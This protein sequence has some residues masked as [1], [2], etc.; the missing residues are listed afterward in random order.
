MN[1][2]TSVVATLIFVACLP[3]LHAQKGAA[4]D[5]QS[6]VFCWVYLCLCV[7]ACMCTCVCVHVCVRVHRIIGGALYSQECGFR[8]VCTQRVNRV[9]RKGMR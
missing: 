6:K 8:I 3:A 1:S 9:P 4:L 5:L 2:R 7:C